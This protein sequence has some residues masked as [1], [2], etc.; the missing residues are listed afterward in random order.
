MSKHDPS[1]ENLNDREGD[2]VP[3]TIRQIHHSNQGDVDESDPLHSAV[4][5]SASQPVPSSFRFH[6]GSQS[7]QTSEQLADDV[8]QHYTLEMNRQT[9]VRR[10]S[11]SRPESRDIGPRDDATQFRTSLPVSS[12]ASILSDSHHL[13]PSSQTSEQPASDENSHTLEI[14]QETADGPLPMLYMSVKPYPAIDGTMINEMI[15]E[16]RKANRNITRVTAQEPVTVKSLK[17]MIQMIMRGI[18]QQAQTKLSFSQFMDVAVACWHY[19]CPMD[20]IEHRADE[21]HD[22]LWKNDFPNRMPE[23]FR[24]WMF[25]ALIFGWPDVFASASMALTSEYK[26]SDD[27]KGF[28]P[29]AL[30]CKYSLEFY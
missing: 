3:T 30:E 17:F 8:N 13:I 2:A 22:D 18:P 29:E 11:H 20:S 16:D 5:S 9:T 1:T 12:R 24:S 23:Q 10:T 19:R 21:F 14:C 27:E 6:D 28:L 25:L 4:P 7:P 26:A 15:E